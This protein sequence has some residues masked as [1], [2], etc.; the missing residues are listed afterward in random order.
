MK[1]NP[2]VVIDTN[3]FVSALIFGGNPRTCLELARE[4]EI[5]VFSS[6]KLLLELSHKLADKFH[7]SDFEIKDV[8]EGLK[9]IIQVVNPL[10]KLAVV[11][12]DP[13]DNMVLECALEA[14]ADYIV[15]GD[16]KHILALGNFK[17]IQIMSAKEFLDRF[18]GKET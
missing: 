18:Y 6:R 13:S 14:K 3:I 5:T 7:W 12:N 17:G 2:K 1:P 4:G 16:K 8:L 9:K 15:S 11:R 10:M